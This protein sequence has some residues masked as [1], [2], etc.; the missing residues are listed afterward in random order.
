MHGRGTLTL[1]GGKSYIG[2]WFEGNLM[3]SPVQDLEIKGIQSDWQRR[4]Q[5]EK[6][7]M[8]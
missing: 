6:E 7:K 2:D 4:L 1:K 3:S 5:E 8:E